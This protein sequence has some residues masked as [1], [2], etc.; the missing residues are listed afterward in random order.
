MV[1]SLFSPKVVWRKHRVLPLYHDSKT[2][3]WSNDVLLN[4]D[5]NAQIGFLKAGYIYETCKSAP[6]KLTKIEDFPVMQN[7]TKEEELKMQRKI[8]IEMGITRNPLT[9]E[10][11][12]QNTIQLVFDDEFMNSPMT[13]N[14]LG[15]NANTV[16]SALHT[17]FK[18]LMKTIF[19]EEDSPFYHQGMDR[20]VLSLLQR[21]LMSKRSNRL[22]SDEEMQTCKKYKTL[23]RHLEY[24]L[25][26]HV[27]THASKLL[28]L[29]TGETEQPATL[30]YAF[31]PFF[32]V[33]AKELDDISDDAR[34]DAVAY[35]ILA[36]KMETFEQQFEP[37]HNTLLTFL[38]EKNVSFPG[39]ALMD[40]SVAALRGCS[41][42]SYRG[43]RARKRPSRSGSG[44]KRR[45]RT[46]KRRSRSPSRKG[47][48]RRR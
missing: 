29:P 35:S 39:R 13:M 43:G 16:R 27:S 25:P 2:L 24:Y 8:G 36:K 11:R 12:A 26:D 28:F 32:D 30:D 44:P 15:T 46:S 10:Q 1:L 48:S 42:T 38:E 21:K 47:K 7:L 19:L 34:L 33:C 31:C 17:N 18:N 45:R 41:T 37:F 22:T 40:S 4:G 3:Y 6:T 23:L 9:K 14:I 20:V 5:V